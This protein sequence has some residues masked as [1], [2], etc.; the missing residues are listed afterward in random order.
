[1]KVLISDNLSPIGVEILK[2]AGFEVDARSKTSAE[3][4]EKIIGEYDALIIRSATKVT[5]GL[6]E[7][8]TKLKVV[9]RAGS[10]LDNVDT[11]AATKKGVVVMNTPGGNTV[12]T[13]E[14]TIGMIF[15]CA[16]MI[17]QSYASLKAGK[18]EK[19][20]FEGV[21]LYDKTLGVVGMG[22][23]GGVVAS[24]AIG[25]G[26]KVLA[27]DP[28]ISPEK[29]KSLGIELA[30]LPTLYKR[31]D[32][33]T[34]HTPKTKETSN[35][36]NK[37]TI[38]QMKDGVRIINCAR[39]G[40]VNEAD[41]FEALK[42]GKVAAAAFDVFEK[43][44]PE[45]HPLLTLDN[46]IATPHL[47]ASTLEA[48]ENVA[49]AVAEQIVDY[50]IAGTVRNAVNVPSVPADQLPSLSPYINLAERMGL[51][52]SQVIEG[53]IT[54]VTV[55]YS[56][57]VSNLKLEPV[58]LAALKGLLTPMIQEN[59]N[60]V[61][62]P[63]IAKD[64]GIEV[65]VS[66]SD[67]TTEYTSLVTLKVKA[68]GK[69]SSVAGTLNSKK[70]PRIVQVDNFPMETVPEGDMLVLMNND[71]PGVI[72]GIGTLMG[73]NGINIA[74]MQFG[75]EKQGGRAMSVVSVDSVIPD[76]VMDAVRKLPNVLS[77]KQ[78]RI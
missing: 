71:K 29:A 56:G 47:G 38:G 54:Q 52:T 25:L 44:P 16:R 37:N 43:E 8:A 59:V 69:D 28:F 45:N 72:G 22:A 26:M 21:E 67:D 75:R 63:L 13:A 58:T 42:S 23:I 68:G 20:K 50:L 27:Y 10:G 1:M 62:A 74:R 55:E 15:A 14:H 65:K 31:S 36:I 4:I 41:L 3:E 18:W 60:Y 48:Q 33:I 39:G 32:F 6:L 19:K 40:I 70:E 51:F 61:N 30:D 49:T 53:G 57:E 17:P 12:T 77:V 2:K 11:P 66:K 7:K 64:R 9:G 76:N 73:Q 35:L 24:R 78:V 34:V 5:A 46:F